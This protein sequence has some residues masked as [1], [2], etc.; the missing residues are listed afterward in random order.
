MLVKF[1]GVRGSIPSPNHSTDIRWK[2]REIL[3]AAEERVLDGPDKMDNFISDLPYHLLHPVGDNTSCIEVSFGEDRII[4]DAGSG[5]RLL[6]LELSRQEHDLT[7]K[8]IYLALEAGHDLANF[9]YRSQDGGNLNLTLLLSH[10]HWDHIQKVFPF[11]PRPTAPAT[12]WPSTART[13]SNWL[14]PSGSSR[15]PRPCSRFLW[16]T[17]APGLISTIFRKKD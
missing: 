14:G 6:G 5:L 1:W 17:W 15:P 16:K 2:L 8:D 13:A 12:A 7:E 11:S 3:A 4:L 9:T 10:T